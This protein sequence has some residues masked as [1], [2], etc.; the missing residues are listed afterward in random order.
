M[1]TTRWTSGAP[2]GGE[3]GD[4]ATE[5]AEVGEG[6]WRWRGEG[7]GRRAAGGLAPRVL[8]DAALRQLPQLPHSTEHPPTLCSARR[9]AAEAAAALAAA[10]VRT[11]STSVHHHASHD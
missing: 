5:G 10:A 4:G 8:I 3:A 7:G 9:A 6:G 1:T 11:T 2:E